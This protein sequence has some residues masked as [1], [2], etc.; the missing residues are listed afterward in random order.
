MKSLAILKFALLTVMAAAAFG[1][2]QA[3]G[4]ALLV[5][6]YFNPSSGY[7]D[8][9][10]YAARRVPLVAI[11]NIFNGPG[12]DAAPRADYVRA[13]QSVRDAGGQVIG[14]VY[15]Q[16]GSR[17]ADTVKADMLRWHQF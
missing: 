2:S 4:V 5:P 15:S 9:L 17:A 13:M 6:A 1:A 8:Q 12:T 3:A 10:S 14:Y 16:Y 11:A 7:W